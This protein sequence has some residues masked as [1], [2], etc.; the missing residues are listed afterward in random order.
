[1]NSIPKKEAKKTNNVEATFLVKFGL[2]IYSPVAKQGFLCNIVK[3]DKKCH[4][5]Q[6]KSGAYT[7]A[8]RHGGFVTR[9][10]MEICTG[11]AHVLA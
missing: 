3:E 11:K 10:L 4:E 6:K 9:V 1:M 8:G 2:A 7:F 5:N